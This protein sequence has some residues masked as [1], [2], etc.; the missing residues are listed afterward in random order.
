MIRTSL[1]ILILTVTGTLFAQSENSNKRL[2][3]ARK[4]PLYQAVFGQKKTDYTEARFLGDEKLNKL[5]SEYLE[6][7]N[8]ALALRLDR[9]KMEFFKI[10]KFEELTEKKSFE[11]YTPFQSR[12]QK[13]QFN[14][15]KHYGPEYK[16]IKDI[17]QEYQPRLQTPQ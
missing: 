12:K 9:L 11:S 15:I 7:R 16:G 8:S 17:F 5:K 10:I 2:D 13:P 1:L 6:S 14:E 3:E 4:N